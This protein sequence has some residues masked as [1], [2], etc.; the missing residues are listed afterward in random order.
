MDFPEVFLLRIFLY[1]DLNDVF[2]KVALLY[3][4]YN[5]FTK[6]H[7]H[8]ILLAINKECFIKITHRLARFGTLARIPDTRGS[9]I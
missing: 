1:L 6:L 8:S 5:T 4:C 9:V 7:L 3:K 2:N